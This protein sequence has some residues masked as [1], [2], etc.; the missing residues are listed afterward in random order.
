MM[1]ND[2]CRKLKEKQLLG[3]FSLN[4]PGPGL[5]RQLNR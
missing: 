4:K 5:G 2:Q 1:K 3:K